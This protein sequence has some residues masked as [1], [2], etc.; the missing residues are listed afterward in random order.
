M[1]V[2]TDTKLKGEQGYGGTKKNQD[3]EAGSLILAPYVLR[4]ELMTLVQTGIVLG[5]FFFT[6]FG[7]SPPVL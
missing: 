7:A 3:K 6:C 4:D 5:F 2:W 1:T